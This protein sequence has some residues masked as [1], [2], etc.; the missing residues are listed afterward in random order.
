MI[1]EDLKF[2]KC[3]TNHSLCFLRVVACYTQAQDSEAREK[4]DESAGMPLPDVPELPSTNLSFNESC[5]RASYA[6]WGKRSRSL[7]VH[8]GKMLK[9]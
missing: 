3:K 8:T 6:G 2:L 7:V 9:A 4:W 1:P 5:V